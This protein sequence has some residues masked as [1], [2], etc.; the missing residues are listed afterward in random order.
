MNEAVLD[1]IAELK[2]RQRAMWASGDYPAI[3]GM[4]WGSAHTSSIAWV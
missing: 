3:A 4:I 2:Q 1:E